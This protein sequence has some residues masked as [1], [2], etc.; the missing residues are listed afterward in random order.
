MALLLRRGG[1]S[2]WAG[3]RTRGDI[4]PF[5]GPGHVF[6][7]RNL[8]NA[9]VRHGAR[10]RLNF[11][12]TIHNKDWGRSVPGTPHVH[13][14]NCALRS[15]DTSD[16]TDARYSQ[17]G[18]GTDREYPQAGSCQTAKDDGGRPGVKF[19]ARSKRGTRS[20]TALLHVGKK[21]RRRRFCTPLVER[22]QGR[23]RCW[24]CSPD[25]RNR[26]SIISTNTQ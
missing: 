4:G 2:K 10:T 1:W 14:C 17:D 16:D 6:E 8:M 22:E 19:L 25:D 20:R 23:R 12:R 11:F 24:W 26:R 15:D 13:R 9:G 5:V 3:R 21:Q 18:Q 7:R